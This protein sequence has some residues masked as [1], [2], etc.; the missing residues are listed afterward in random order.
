MGRG[1]PAPSET[2]ST[3]PGDAIR[4]SGPNVNSHAPATVQAGHLG[5]LEPVS[6]AKQR[7]VSMRVRG[8]SAVDHYQLFSHTSTLV[9]S[10]AVG[11]AHRLEL[12]SASTLSWSRVEARQLVPWPCDSHRSSVSMGAAT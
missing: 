2:A 5:H 6:R 7:T 3:V 8:P 12:P 9:G 10:R 4:I 1:S 11:G